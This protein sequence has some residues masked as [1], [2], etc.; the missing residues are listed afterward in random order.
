[1]KLCW[2][3]C[4]AILAI[5]MFLEFGPMNSA[6]NIPIKDMDAT[7]VFLAAT[8]TTISWLA[9]VLAFSHFL[10]ELE[11]HCPFTAIEPQH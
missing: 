9:L 8:I 1:M 5:K 2:T 6:L 10:R 11:I 7:A 3:G 4:K